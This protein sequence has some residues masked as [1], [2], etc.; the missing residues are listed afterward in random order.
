VSTSTGRPVRI[1]PEVVQRFT[2]E[3]L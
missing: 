2:L 1:P 3:P